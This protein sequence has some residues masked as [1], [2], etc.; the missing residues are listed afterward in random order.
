LTRRADPDAGLHRIDT[1]G[2]KCPWPVLRAARAM[3]EQGAVLVLSDD[4]VALTDMPALAAAHGWAI[5][6]REHDGHAE[7]VLKKNDIATSC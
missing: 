3:R 7:F 4:R 1:R 2:L 5:S 6:V